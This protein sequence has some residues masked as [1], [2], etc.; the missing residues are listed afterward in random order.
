[1]DDEDLETLGQMVDRLDSAA[2]GALLPVAPD[3]HVQGMRGVI[4][5]ARDQLRA[6]L[7]GKGF[8]PWA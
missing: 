8:N 4:K 3:I 7:V 1:M 5:D 6:F 2:R